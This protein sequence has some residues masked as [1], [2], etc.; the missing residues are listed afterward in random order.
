MPIIKEKKLRITSYVENLSVTGAVEGEPEQTSE[1]ADCFFKISEGCYEI[2][3]RTESE[4]GP[5]ISDLKA[6]PDTVTVKRTGALNSEM[7][8]SEGKEDVSLYS[9]P[10][11]SF[12][13][14][15]FTK[16]IRSSLDRDG[17]RIDIFYRMSVGGADKNVRM[18][19]EVIS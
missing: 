11:Y 7:K 9:I 3:W 13:M 18:K 1:S 16:K 10:P 19:I 8:F 6:E 14:K 2:T 15:I 4:G 12:D 5:I 17:G